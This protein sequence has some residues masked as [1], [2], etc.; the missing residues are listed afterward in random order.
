[1]KSRLFCVTLI[2]GWLLVPN[3]LVRVFQKLQICWDLHTQQ[4]LEFTQNG[5]KNKQWCKKTCEVSKE[6]GMF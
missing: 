6:L 2:G 5:V 3:G 1:M 4:S